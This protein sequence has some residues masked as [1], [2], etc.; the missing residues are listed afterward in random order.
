MKINVPD[1]F[2]NFRCIADKCHDSCCI[3]WEIDIDSEAEAKYKALNTPIGKEICEK[4]SHGYFP[5]TKDGRCAFLDKTGL[6]RIISTLGEGYLCDICR[7]HPRYYGVGNGCIEGGLGLGCEEAARIILS[8]KELPELVYTERDI[9]YCDKDE[10]S[11]ISEYFRE[12]L[13]S[14]IFTLDIHNLIGKY[15]EFA[16]IADD[17][18]FEACTSENTVQ[19]PKL[20]YTGAEKKQIKALLTDMLSLLRECE[21]L[22]DGWQSLIDRAA[23]VDISNILHREGCIRSMLY[24]FT[25]RYVREGIAD[26]SLGKRILFALGST[27]TIA[28]LANIICDNNSE[29]KA[30]VTYSKNVEY[31]TD[32][33]DFIL[34]NIDFC[35]L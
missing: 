8:L 34:E 12:N 24:Y 6:C 25:H 30:A 5:L 27:L 28:A 10:F 32:N 15:I 20:T 21:A 14:G 26:I 19:I 22:Y 35:K 16:K 3:G 2:L 18:A 29:I 11:D 17:V 7:E 33:T 13:Y 1:Y 9:P 4:T 31:S 23:N